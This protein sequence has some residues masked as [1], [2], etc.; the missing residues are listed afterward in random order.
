MTLKEFLELL[1][2]S[3]PIEVRSA[4]NG[5]LLCKSYPTGK[6]A[7]LLDRKVVGCHPDIRIRDNGWAQAYMFIYVDG[8][9][10]LKQTMN[11]MMHT[12]TDEKDEW[13]CSLKT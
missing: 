12:N 11:S 6:K 1:T 5:K 9:E 4:Y 13:L 7:A 8:M 2:I 10:E 3:S